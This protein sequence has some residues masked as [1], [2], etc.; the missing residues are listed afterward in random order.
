MAELSLDH[1][2]TDL[3]G[4]PL[5]VRFLYLQCLREYAQHLGHADILREQITAS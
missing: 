1:V 4:R 5:S 3:R 2:L